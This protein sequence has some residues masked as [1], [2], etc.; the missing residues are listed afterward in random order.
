MMKAKIVF[1]VAVVVAFFLLPT[2]PMNSTSVNQLQDTAS[3]T[4]TSTTLSAFIGYWPVYMV[5]T[6]MWIWW[7]EI[8]NFARGKK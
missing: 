4:I 6:L 5:A 1:S 8:S 7:R 2:L 3:S